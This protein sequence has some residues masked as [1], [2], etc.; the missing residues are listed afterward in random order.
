MHEAWLAKT[1]LRNA[2]FSCPVKV[3]ERKYLGFR[4]E[5]ENG[6]SL[7]ARW[8]ALPYGLRSAAALFDLTAKGLKE[9]YLKNGALPTTLYYLD[10][11][12]TIASTKEQCQNSL[13]IILA[14]C[15]NCGF[16]VQA[17][18]TEGPSK[19]IT[20]LGLEIDT[21]K[22]QVRIPESKQA[23]INDEL[24]KWQSKQCATKREILSLLGKLNFCAQV[25]KNGA[26]FTR[27]LIECAKKG[28]TLNSKLTLNRQTQKDIKWWSRCMAIYNGRE[29]FPRE[30]DIKTAKLTFSDASDIAI[31]G[32]YENSWYVIPFVGEYKWLAGKSIQYRE[33][34]AVVETIATFASRLRNSQTVIHCDNEAMQLSIVSGKSKVPELMGLIRA[35]YFYTATHHIEYTC[36]HIRSKIN[37]NSDRLSRLRMIEFYYYLPTADKRMTRP[38]RIIRDF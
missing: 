17:K 28:K 38:A 12:V 16:E 26:K 25:V 23:E 30:I 5:D 13:D 6:S 11:I 3:E 8:A 9:I 1:D 31:G 20:Y 21:V 29:W 4:F 37:A 18:K 14:T 10:D 15:R 33:L 34:Y 2:Y 24:V 7:P 36:L 32:M 22:R 27:R 19:V 35:L